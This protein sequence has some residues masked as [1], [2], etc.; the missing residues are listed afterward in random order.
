MNAEAGLVDLVLEEEL[1][2]EDCDEQADVDLATEVLMAI[3]PYTA[4]PQD[5]AKD[6]NTKLSPVPLSV[7]AE[8]EAYDQHRMAPFNRHR[9]GAQVSERPVSHTL[10]RHRILRRPH[11]IC[12]WSPLLWSRIK[13]MR[14][15]FWATSKTTT[16]K[17]QVFLCS[18]THALASGPRAGWNGCARPLD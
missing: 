1:G 7:V 6:S 3:L 2:S 17:T 18:P 16:A 14:Y 9:V 8:L 4:A 5:E 11:V 13:Q 15:G 12:R 10:A